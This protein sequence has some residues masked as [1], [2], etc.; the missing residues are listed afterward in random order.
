MSALA[1]RNIN[2]WAYESRPSN[3]LLFNAHQSALNG[4]NIIIEIFKKKQHSEVYH[5][6]HKNTLTYRVRE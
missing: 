5:T 4:G 1:A 3:D 6:S 2:L